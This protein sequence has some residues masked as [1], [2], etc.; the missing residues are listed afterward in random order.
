MQHCQNTKN[1]RKL[2]QPCKV[3]FF[4]ILLNSFLF[5]SNKQNCLKFVEEPCFCMFFCYFSVVLWISIVFCSFCSFFV[6]LFYNIKNIR[7]RMIYGLRRNLK[8]FY[9]LFLFVRIEFFVFFRVFGV[10]DWI[11]GRN[12]F[13]RLG[14]HELK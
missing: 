4:Q 9:K 10:A 5:F 8:I 1:R 3:L 7:T 13:W 12:S 14:L 11:F 2:G 6:I